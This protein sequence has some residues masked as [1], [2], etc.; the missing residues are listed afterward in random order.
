MPVEFKLPD[1]GEGIHEGEIIEVLVRVGDK[2]EDGQPVLIVETDKASAEVPAPVT[3]TV[4]E[5][6]VK[7]GQTVRVGD[8]MMIFLGEGESEKEETPERPSMKAAPDAEQEAHPPEEKGAP[9]AEPQAGPVPA[10][11]STRRLAR[12]LGVD[13]RHVKPSGPGGRITPEDVRTAAEEEKKPAAHPPEK[14]EKPTA[15]PEPPPLPQF[16]QTGT[17]ERISL[18]SIRRATARHVALSWSQIPH[19]SHMDVADI[20]EL[21]KFRQKYRKKVE[22]QGGTLSLTVLMLK[23]AASAL[24]KFPRFNSSLDTNTDE[25]ILKRYYNIGVAVDTERGLIVPVIRD[26]DRKSLVDLGTELKMTAEK[27]RTGKTAAEDLAGGSFTITNIGPLGGTSF[28]PIINYPQVAILGMAQARL[29]PIVFGDENKNQIVPRL[30]LPLIITFDHR[31]IDGADA[32]RF[33]TSIIE[34]LKNPENL[35]LVM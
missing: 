6:R 27:A 8:V 4:L 12:E 26:V 33:L 30:I 21:E 35:M 5:I 31:V 9:T 24:R 2:V 14:E 15:P 32:A 19:V 7:P 22:E 1:L 20:T 10:T 25:I 18:R 17:V 23:A 34:S 11:P 29:Q 16:D 3:G 13:L 28:N